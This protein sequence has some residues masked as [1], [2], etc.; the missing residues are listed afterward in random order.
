MKK[1]I[2]ILTML[3]LLVGC[4]SQPTE[5]VTSVP[6]D[7]EVRTDNVY[8][9]AT[10]QPTE[11]PTQVAEETE[12]EV[13]TEIVIPSSEIAMDAE[14]DEHPWEV[15]GCRSISPEVLI[16]IHRAGY[17]AFRDSDDENLGRL[18][19]LMPREPVAICTLD[20]VD[21]AMHKARVDITES[22]VKYNIPFE[23]VD[24]Q[25]WNGDALVDAKRFIDYQLAG[26]W[27]NLGEKLKTETMKTTILPDGTG[28]TMERKPDE[29]YGLFPKFICRVTED[30]AIYWD[31]TSGISPYY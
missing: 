29:A 26:C 3:F 17:I 10:E 25:H 14:L 8:N 24:V 9:I 2:A 7:S 22:F 28:K 23:V 1:S 27:S 4:G 12:E 5:N 6:K 18:V 31:Y 20:E 11:V 15:W 19:Y 21:E 16:D 30:W 13:P